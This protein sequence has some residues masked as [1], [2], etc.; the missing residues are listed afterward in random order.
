MYSCTRIVVRFS[1]Q[2]AREGI[3]RLL[4]NKHR[5]SKEHL[6]FLNK[7][8]STRQPGCAGLPVRAYRCIVIK[9]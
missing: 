7:R 8:F 5:Q 6:G 2:L 4:Y 3:Y 1:S 9:L